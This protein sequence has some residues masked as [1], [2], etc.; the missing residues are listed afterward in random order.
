VSWTLDNAEERAAEAPRSFFIPPADL[1]HSLKVGD[2]VK[3]IFCLERGDGEAAVERMWVEVVETQ[4]Y[5]GL[6]RNVPRL[7]GVVDFG[8]RVPFGAEHVCAYTYTS[9]ELGYDADKRCVLLKR[10]AEAEAPPPLLLLNGEGCWEAHARDES[11]EELTDSENGLVW[12]LGYLT[13]RF[14]QTAEAL[15]DGT[16]RRGILRRRQRHVVWEWDGSRY[17]RIEG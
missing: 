11:E 15:R 5:V 1:R 14:P 12:T 2:E 6:L 8:D 10:V 13:D 16:S 3:L 4:P 9:E 7:S 17:V